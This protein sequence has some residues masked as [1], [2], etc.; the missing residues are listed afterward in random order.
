[1][2]GSRQDLGQPLDRGPVR[3][4]AMD[5]EDVGCTEWPRGARMAGRVTVCWNTGGFQ[6]VGAGIQPGGR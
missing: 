6:V 5:G 3:M 4:R 2:A 1:M